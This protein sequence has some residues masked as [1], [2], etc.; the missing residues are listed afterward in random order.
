MMPYLTFPLIIL[1]LLHSLLFSMGKEEQIR[2]LLDRR[3]RE[4]KE[5][6]GPEGKEYTQKQ[7]M[8]LQNIINDIIDYSAMARFALADTYKELDENQRDE[9]VE[10]FSKIIRDQSLRQ[11]DIYRAE[12]IYEDIS[13]EEKEALVVTTAVLQERRIPVSYRMKQKEDIW[14]ISDMSIDEAWTAESYKRS[15]QNIIRRRGYE[16]LIENLRRRA[17]EIDR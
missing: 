4:I 2:D 15:F 16:A 12:V 5:L 6:L 14:M 10:V 9:F 7:R 11:L 8:E 17:E 13:V 3:D 1:F